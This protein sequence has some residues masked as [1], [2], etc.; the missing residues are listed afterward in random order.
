MALQSWTHQSEKLCA[1][2]MLARVHFRDITAA[3]VSITDEIVVTTLVAL[4]ALERR[5]RHPLGVTYQRKVA[6]IIG[7]LKLMLLIL[8]PEKSYS[9]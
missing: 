6:P 9:R 3:R 8:V 4:A 7:P 1:V 5:T 2:E